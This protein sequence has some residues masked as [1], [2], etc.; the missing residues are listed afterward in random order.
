VLAVGHG[1]ALIQP[2]MPMSL[3]IEEARRGHRRK[4]G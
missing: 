2:A 3:A 1:P 4:N